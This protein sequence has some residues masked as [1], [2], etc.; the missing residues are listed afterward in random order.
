MNPEKDVEA[1]L[2]FASSDG[3]DASITINFYDDA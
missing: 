2:V 3:K 1:F